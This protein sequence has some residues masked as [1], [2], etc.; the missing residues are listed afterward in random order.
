FT[1]TTEGRVRC[2]PARYVATM[3]LFGS[4]IDLVFKE[5]VGKNQ[6]GHS[7]DDDNSAG[8]HTGIVSAFSGYLC[9]LSSLVDGL[10]RTHDCG[11]RLESGAERNIH[12]VR[13]TALYASGKIS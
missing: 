7:L 11:Y 3:G 4:M 10:L 5:V 2:G 13:Y 12:A 8:Y 9:G 1:D 6:G